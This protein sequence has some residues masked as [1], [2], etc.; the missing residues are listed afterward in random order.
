MFQLLQ[1]LV[2]HLSSITVPPRNVTW[3]PYPDDKYENLG[4]LVQDFLWPVHF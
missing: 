4:K 2:Q 1:K 3:D